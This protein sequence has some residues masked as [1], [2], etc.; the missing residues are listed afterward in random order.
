MNCN[1]SVA[2]FASI[3]TLLEAKLELVAKQI[4]GKSKMD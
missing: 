1:A 4:E 2:R 3:V